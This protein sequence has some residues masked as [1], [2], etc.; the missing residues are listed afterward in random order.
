MVE[1]MRCHTG[2]RVHEDEAVFKRPFDARPMRP[3]RSSD[4]LLH[5]DKRDP[6]KMSLRQKPANHPVSLTQGEA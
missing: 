5:G 4:P 2:F 1:R 3:N 6:H